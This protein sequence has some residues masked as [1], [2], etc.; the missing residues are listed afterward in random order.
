MISAVNSGAVFSA[1]SGISTIPSWYFTTTPSEKTV[2]PKYSSSTNPVFIKILVRSMFFQTHSSYSSSTI[3]STSTIYLNDSDRLFI[4]ASACS[5]S[6]FSLF[7][8][9]IAPVLSAKAIVRI[10]VTIIQMII[11][12]KG[13]F[14]LFPSIYLLI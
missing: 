8:L 1:S 11:L 2:G 4:D 10:M 13:C 3:L 12:T 5:F 7:M 9:I 14:I 6:L